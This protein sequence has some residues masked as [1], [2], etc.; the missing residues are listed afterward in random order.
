MK[1]YFLIAIII[2]AAFLLSSCG[3][4]N[5]SDT[6]GEGE[7]SSN[8]TTAQDTTAADTTEAETTEKVAMET[9]ELGVYLPGGLGVFYDLSERQYFEIELPSAGTYV[10]FDTPLV[11]FESEKGYKLEVT[12]ISRDDKNIY[13]QTNNSEYYFNL[14]FLILTPEGEYYNSFLATGEEKIDGNGKRYTV[15]ETPYRYK[16][17]I[18]I[19][20]EDMPR[21]A[22][23]KKKDVMNALGDK[24]DPTKTYYEISLYYVCD[25]N[26]VYI[27]SNYQ[28]NIPEA[29]YEAMYGNE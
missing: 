8:D 2:L 14:H 22:E 28:Y 20:I 29:L 11:L 10:T 21:L 5:V 1:K 4:G 27:D 26:G 23:S 15:Y 16:T 24:Y 13:F 18:Y 7:M 19:H 3:Y 6:T 25:S 17:S 9:N 12:A